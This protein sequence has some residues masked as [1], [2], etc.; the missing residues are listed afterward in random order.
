MNLDVVHVVK[1][2]LDSSITFCEFLPMVGTGFGMLL[3]V[4]NVDG[5]DA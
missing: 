2:I 3:L 5:E 4:M 1:C